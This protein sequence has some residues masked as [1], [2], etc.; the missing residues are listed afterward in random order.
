[1][2]NKYVVGLGEA[3]WD[4]VFPTKPYNKITLTGRAKHQVFNL[5]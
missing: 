2:E 5:K 4:L 3:L 1:M